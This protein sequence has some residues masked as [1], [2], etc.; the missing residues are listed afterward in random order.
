M[1]TFILACIVMTLS[2]TLQ[3]AAGFGGGLVAVPLLALVSLDY[4]PGPFLGSSLVLTGMIA[5]RGRRDIARKHVLPVLA[6]LALGTISAVQILADLPI[7]YLSLAFGVMVLIAAAAT[8]AGV[9]IPFTGRAGS[10]AGALAGLM[11]ATTGSGAHVLAL[12]FR[13][14]DG[15]QLRATLATL[16]LVAMPFTLGALAAAGQ[17]DTRD[18]LLGLELLPGTVIGYLIA[19]AIARKLDRGYSRIVI[20]VI[21]S[22]T[23]IVLV[24]RS[25]SQIFW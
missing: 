13:H 12:F 6:G 1:A 8:Y 23:S 21:A 15:K 25:V 2:S 10:I 24:L 3:A 11:G 14:Y 19:P 5:Y 4:V 7:T 17:F 20:L 18:I 16:Y 22:A 9:R